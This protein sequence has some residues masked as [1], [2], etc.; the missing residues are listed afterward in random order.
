MKGVA[1]LLSIL[2]LTSF[3]VVR[4]DNDD[5]DDNDN[6]NNR[7]SNN[8]YDDDEYYA[9]LSGSN[10]SPAINTPT[11]GRAYFDLDDDENGYE[12]AIQ[13]SD[14]QN[15]IMAHIHLGKAGTNGPVIVGLLPKGYPAS[16]FGPNATLPTITPPFTGSNRYSGRFT[17]KDLAGPYAGK[18][19]SA[20]T[21]AFKTGGTYVNLH[22]TK[23][24]AGLVRGQVT[25]QS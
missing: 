9:I 6:D 25:P 12:W 23:Y 10:Q 3:V 18:P 19:L 2:L 13:V 11:S 24:P 16:A 7:S 15:L 1:L 20:L 22:T 21:Q 17:A 8:N 5:D 4:C 14:V